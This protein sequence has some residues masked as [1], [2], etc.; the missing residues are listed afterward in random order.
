MTHPIFG[1]KI[2]NYH[3][4]SQILSWISHLNAGGGVWFT[5]KPVKIVVLKSDCTRV[6][7]CDYGTLP[8]DSSQYGPGS[9]PARLIP[10]NGWLGKWAWWETWWVVW[11]VKRS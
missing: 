1:Y 8:Q 10:W 7:L 9:Q 2:R 5:Q 6:G 4:I 3:Q 11:W